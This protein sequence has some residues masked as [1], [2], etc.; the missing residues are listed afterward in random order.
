MID[1][2]LSLAVP[3]GTYGRVAPRSGLGKNNSYFI[4][5]HVDS[6]DFLSLQIHDR[7]WRRCC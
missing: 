7:H 2:Q 1:T 6:V 4:R 3:L 5:Q